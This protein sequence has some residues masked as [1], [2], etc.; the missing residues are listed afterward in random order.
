MPTVFLF[1]FSQ[2]SSYY[3]FLFKLT[4]TDK[5]ILCITV[6]IHGMSTF[7]TSLIILVL[8]D[9]QFVADFLPLQSLLM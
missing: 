3:S 5:F 8:V 1:F 2:L 9:T 4:F 7:E 6:V